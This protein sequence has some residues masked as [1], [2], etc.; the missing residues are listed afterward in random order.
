MEKS[1]RLIA[2]TQPELIDEFTSFDDY[3]G[4]ERG[5]AEDLISYCARVSSPNNQMN[6]NTSGKLLTY[7]INHKHWSP[8]E[9]VHVV[10]EIKT[11][12]DIG[13]QIL[14]HRSFS[15]QEF[16]Q[17]YAEVKIDDLEF[18]EARLQDFKNRQNSL[19]THS[20]KVHMDWHDLQDE[21]RMLAVKNYK[22]ALELGIAKE[23]AR[24]LLPE[25]L[26]PSLMYMS[27]T[28]RSWIH[29]C[30]IRRGVETQLEHRVIAEECWELLTDKFP[31]LREYEKMKAEK[32]NANKD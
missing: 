28:L 19:Q 18:R 4:Y 13:R 6:Y 31:F 10:M 5:T 9:M 32:S 17:R 22:K 24:V 27:G 23:Q 11:T 29:Y 16:S 25:G 1:V 14:R 15:F 12:R 7:L 2:A 8:F 21:V 30:D 20:D 3:G 26:K